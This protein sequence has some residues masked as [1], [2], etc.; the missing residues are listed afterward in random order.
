MSKEEFPELKRIDY[1]YTMTREQF[2]VLHYMQQNGISNNI[3]AM[4]L[5]DIYNGEMKSILGGVKERT[6]YTYLRRLRDMGYVGNGYKKQKE[7]SYYITDKGLQKIALEIK[8]AGGD[9]SWL[10]I[11]PR[12]SRKPKTKKSD[13]EKPLTKKEVEDLIN[14]LTE[15]CQVIKLEESEIEQKGEDKNVKE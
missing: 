9:I 10:D 7:Q 8:L 14:E 15:E 2:V 4:T 5:K 12:K 1:N 3:K 6:L 13:S 11:K